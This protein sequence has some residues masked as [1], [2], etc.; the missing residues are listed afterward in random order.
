MEAPALSDVWKAVISRLAQRH[1][2]QWRSVAASKSCRLAAH[3]RG[4]HRKPECSPQRPQR[5]SAR[6]APSVLGWPKPEVWRGAA[7][8]ASIILNSA[9]VLVEGTIAR[10]VRPCA[11]CGGGSS[12]GRATVR[13]R[14]DLRRIRAALKEGVEGRCRTSACVSRASP[15]SGAAAV[16]EDWLGT[17]LGCGSGSAVAA[18]SAIWFTAA[19]CFCIAEIKGHAGDARRRLRREGA[20]EPLIRHQRDIVLRLLE[21]RLAAEDRHLLEQPG[22]RPAAS[23]CRIKR[24]F[25]ASEVG[26]GTF[27]SGARGT[28]LA[29]SGTATSLTAPRFTSPPKRPRYG[30]RIAENAKPGDATRAQHA[31]TGKGRKNFGFMEEGRTDEQADRRVGT[32]GR[33]RGRGSDQSIN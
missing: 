22:K 21:S 29:S 15:P 1:R 6:A 26:V 16:T 30:L 12:A 13:D 19:E 10:R 7:S 31:S 4:S 28:L 24:K 27:G 3:P 33:H 23:T 32:R 20:V 2:P 14:A 8:I 9:R 25:A 18:F 11:C 17:T 5:Y